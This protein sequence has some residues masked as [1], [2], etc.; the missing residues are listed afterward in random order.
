[1]ALRAFAI[2]GVS[3]VNRVEEICTESFR[4]VTRLLPE[5]NPLT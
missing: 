3:A 2:G 4:Q 5:H 1:M